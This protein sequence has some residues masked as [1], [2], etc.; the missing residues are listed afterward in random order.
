MGIIALSIRG[1]IQPAGITDPIAPL[2]IA[3]VS[4][5]DAATEADPFSVGDGSR[6][7]IPYA[8]SGRLENA[9]PLSTDALGAN[10]T[11]ECV[12]TPINSISS[13]ATCL[14]AALALQ[15][16]LNAHEGYSKLH[17]G[18]FPNIS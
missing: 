8:R 1:Q 9:T 4:P 12:P 5:R 13:P 7:T 14:L 18:A 2:G 15:T 10:A 11:E 16:I 17:K 3:A 6:S